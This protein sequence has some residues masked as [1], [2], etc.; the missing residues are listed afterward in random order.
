MT[1]ALVASVIAALGLV[2]GGC[3][4]D[5]PV[6]PATRAVIVPVTPTSARGFIDALALS[7]DGT[8]AAIGERTGAIQIWSTAPEVMPVALGDYRQ[9]VVDL[10]FAPGGRLLASLGRHRESLLRLW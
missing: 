3:E 6:A 1:R 8:L 10:A 9:S 7:P 4:R 2:G 5:A